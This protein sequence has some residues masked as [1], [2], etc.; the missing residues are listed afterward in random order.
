LTKVAL[1]LRERVGLD[2]RQRFRLVGV[3]LSNFLDPEDV[4][5]QPGLFE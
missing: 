2:S 3:A 5:A 4:S 1:S